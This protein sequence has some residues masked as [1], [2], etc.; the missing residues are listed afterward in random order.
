MLKKEFE[1]LT[2]IYPSDALYRCIEEKYMDMPMV[3]KDSFCNHYKNNTDGIAERIQMVANEAEIAC[4]KEHEEQTTLLKKE[5]D[6]LKEELRKTKRKLYLEE[7][8]K[9]YFNPELLSQEAYLIQQ[10]QCDYQFEKDAAML[11]SWLHNNFGFAQEAVIIVTSIPAEEI[12]RHG[13]IR[14]IKDKEYDRRPVYFASDLNYILFEC[15]GYL[16]ECIDGE[17]HMRHY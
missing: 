2:G 7:E 8:W 12:N 13:M 10:K 9:E 1:E 5:I 11:K 14:R 3:R 16:Y 4:N 6:S 17:L 15:R